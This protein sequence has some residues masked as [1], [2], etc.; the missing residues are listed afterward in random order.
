MALCSGEQERFNFWEVTVAVKLIIRQKILL[1]SLET[2]VIL[3]QREFVNTV[4]FPDD[5]SLIGISEN[6][7]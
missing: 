5:L 3:G 1:R 7:L 6:G 2:F 4:L